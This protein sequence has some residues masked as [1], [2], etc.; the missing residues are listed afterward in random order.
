[1]DVKW[2]AEQLD[3]PG[4]SQ[5]GLARALGKDAAAVNRM[6]KGER[7]IKANEIAVILDYLQA[8]PPPGDRAA[9]FIAG[10]PGAAGVM[11][12]Q[13]IQRVTDGNG[14]PDV[15]VWASAEAG[16]DGAMVRLVT[17]LPAGVSEREAD[18]GLAGFARLAAP[19]LP[20]FIPD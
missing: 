4:F 11:P 7:L 15:P 12:T 14:R 6:L 17:A 8:A 20:R 2:I 19:V 3:R 13:T 18:A 1:M 10:G 5:A 9:A 16:T